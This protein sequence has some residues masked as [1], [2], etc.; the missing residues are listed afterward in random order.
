MR[1]KSK[2]FKIDDFQILHNNNISNV[3]DFD[4]DMVD[5]FNASQTPTPNTLLPLDENG[6]YPSSAFQTHNLGDVDTVDGKH[7][8]DFADAT[9]S[10]VDDMIILNK[11]KLV[12]GHGSGL[13]ADTL[14]GMTVDD[15]LSSTGG[16]GSDADTISGYHAEDLYI[17]KVNITQMGKSTVG[18]MPFVVNGKLYQSVYARLYGTT[19]NSSFY[20]AFHK[21]DK[22]IHDGLI[23]PRPTPIPSNI[24]IKKIAGFRNAYAACLLENG[25]LY[26]WGHNGYGACG[27]GHTTIIYTPILV[28][29]DVIDIFDHPTQAELDPLHGR[30]FILKQ[31]GLYAAGYNAFGQ[32]GIGSTTDASTFTKCVGFDNTSSDYIKAV[33]PM[34]S[35]Y[36]FTFVLTSDGKIWFAG[37]N[38]KGV[39]GDGTTTNKNSLIR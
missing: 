20:T 30:L 28:D 9:L 34:E 3:T 32:L 15:I 2:D 22:P 31:D 10:N 16:D 26:T 4:S 7:A 29:T 23:H 14:D 35:T 8:S 25:D 12:D 24:P 13:D 39:A 1:I 19:T 33:Y 27:A 21:P 36:G 18:C 6:K 38:T 11:T 37:S 5:G 17:S